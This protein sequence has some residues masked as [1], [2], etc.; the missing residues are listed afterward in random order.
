[1]SFTNSTLSGLLQNINYE[2][3]RFITMLYRI[4]KLLEINETEGYLIIRNQINKLLVTEDLTQVYSNVKF[5]HPVI[6]IFYEFLGR[7][8]K[9]VNGPEY[10]IK[11]VRLLIDEIIVLLDNNISAKEISNRLKSLNFEMQ[12]IG[13][14]FTTK[15]LI[16]SVLKNAHLSELLY[17]ATEDVNDFDIDKIKIIKV[18][19]GVFN[20]SYVLNGLVLP[21]SP[22][23]EVKQLENTSVAIY[24]C[25]LDLERTELKGTVLLKNAEELLNYSKNETEVIKKIVDNF[26]TNA[27]IV[28]GS[29]N[30]QFLDFCNRRNILVFPVFSRFDLY[31]IANAL[32]AP[33]YT[34]LKEEQRNYK[35][36][37][38]IKNFKDGN[39]PFT[40][41]EGKGLIRTIVLKHSI[42]EVLDEYELKINKLLEQLKGRQIKINKTA[43]AINDTNVV[44]EI[45]KKCIEPGN[46]IYMLDMDK[47]KCFKCVLEFVATLL[48][49]N[50][51]L[52]AH[53]EE[54]DL[55]APPKYMH[56]DH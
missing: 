41:V 20:D 1:M 21:N 14:G 26:M 36:A 49:V 23:G 38:K 4:K 40:V 56:E 15:T 19:T 3:T 16:N 7:A 8:G 44:A 10:F 29:V 39:K 6:K 48:E 42:T 11:T 35:K 28:N 54:I 55:K 52:I 34:S 47:K 27:I 33:V 22:A 32:D 30:N 51:Y 45:V 46:K 12:L 13:N 43:V 18:C 9:Y 50:D 37:S 25:P 5:G 24:D 17:E 31:K 53:K 2:K